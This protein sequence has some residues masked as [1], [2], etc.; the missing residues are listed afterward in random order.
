MHYE[1]DKM[2]SNAEEEEEEPWPRLRGRG[3]RECVPRAAGICGWRSGFE[4]K[5]LGFRV[6]GSRFVETAGADD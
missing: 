6:W 3:T 2:D 4:V 5:D 1:I